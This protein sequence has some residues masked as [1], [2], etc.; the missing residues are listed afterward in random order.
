MVNLSNTGMS[1]AGGRRPDNFV[2]GVIEEPPQVESAV[3]ELNSLGFS[4][5][6]ILILHGKSGADTIRGRDDEPG[7]AGHLRQSWM[8]LSEILSNQLDH[9]K[10]HIEAAE[11]G[12]YVIVVPLPNTDMASHKS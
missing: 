7:F 8:R 1:S 4:D 3:N 2:V 5:D 10:R 11:Q 12:N 9:V 6:A